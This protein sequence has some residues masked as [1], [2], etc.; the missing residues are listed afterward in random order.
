VFP[1]FFLCS[2]LFFFVSSFSFFGGRWDRP[3]ITASSLIL[4]CRQKRGPRMSVGNVGWHF[5]RK[6]LPPSP[7]VI[8]F[9]KIL[10]RFFFGYLVLLFRKV[11]NDV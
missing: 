10:T 8:P 1:T 7:D 3:L 2:I 6:W 9:A 4:E 11:E 5:D